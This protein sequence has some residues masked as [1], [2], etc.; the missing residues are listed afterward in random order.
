VERLL[1]PDLIL[2]GGGISKRAD[3]FLPLIELRTPLRPAR[4]R[5][6]AGIVGAALLAADDDSR[7]IAG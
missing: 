2:I 1:W 7:S 5:N 3:E 4:L 6:Q